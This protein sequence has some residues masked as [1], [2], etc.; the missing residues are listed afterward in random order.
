MAVNHVFR[1]LVSVTLFFCLHSTVQVDQLKSECTSRGLDTTG[2]KADLISRLKAHETGAGKKA[3]T[4]DSTPAASDAAPA[5]KPTVK[6]GK[7]A[8][9]AAAAP[10]PE[11]E[12][13]KSK[14]RKQFAALSTQKSS[15]LRPN[16]K[17]D[18]LSYYT[19]SHNVYSSATETFDAMLNQTNIGQNNNKYYVIQ[20]LKHKTMNSYTTW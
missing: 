19:N 14:E 11:P 6:R 18:S 8:A 2:R 13:A 17:V 5:V 20:V 3:K 12:D 9:K 1:R 10:A 15:K 4:S 16:A 7:S